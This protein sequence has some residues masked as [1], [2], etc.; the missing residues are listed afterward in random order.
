MQRAR[1]RAHPTCLTSA[2]RFCCHAPARM[3]I[4]SSITSVSARA[5]DPLLSR[6]SAREA[7][8]RPRHA[9]SLFHY[10][11]L[12]HCARN[13]SFSFILYWIVRHCTARN[14]STGLIA[15]AV[16]VNVHECILVVR[17]S[18]LADVALPRDRIEDDALL[19]VR[20]QLCT[21][22][23]TC[24]CKDVSMSHRMNHGIVVARSN[25]VSPALGDFS[26]VARKRRTTRTLKITA[27]PIP[28]CACALSH[29]RTHARTR[30]IHTHARMCT[31]THQRTHTR[32]THVY[33]MCTNAH[34]HSHARS[35]PR[36]R[37]KPAQ[38]GQCCTVCCTCP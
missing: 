4:A 11:A 28:D 8:A 23:A 34:W 29:G 30:V 18:G 17:E 3:A 10:F 20:P 1:V 37:R 33:F 38:S 26:P 14:T 27:I 2:R 12:R 19:L 7:G 35:V 5:R 25:A 15:V 32:S 9:I 22:R 13:R 6:A 21:A 16:R 31:R 24:G 36:M